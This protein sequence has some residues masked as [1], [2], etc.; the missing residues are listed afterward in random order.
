MATFLEN[1]RKVLSGEQQPPPIAQLIGFSL[2]SI[3]PGRAILELDASDRHHNP[4]GTLHGGIYCDLADAAM[5]YACAA[6]LAE[7]ESFTTIELKI[8]FLRGVSQG[9]ITAQ[10]QVVKSGSTI[11]YVECEVKDDQG[12]LVAKVASTCLKMKGSV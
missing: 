5:G 7:G 4:M 9:R 8:N 2:K 6:T 1:A 10:A 11:A 3:E 12:R